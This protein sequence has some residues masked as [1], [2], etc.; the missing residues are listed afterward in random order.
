[1]KNIILLLTF[2]L[3][4]F[5][6]AQVKPA[7]HIDSLFIRALKADTD[8]IDSQ[9]LAHD[10]KWQGFKPN[11]VLDTGNSFTGIMSLSETGTFNLYPVY[12]WYNSNKLVFTTST[13]DQ[14]T[15]KTIIHIHRS[16]FHWLNDTTAI[17]MP[18][19]KP[20]HKIKSSSLLNHSQIP[21]GHSAIMI[22]RFTQFLAA[23]MSAIEQ[24]WPA[25]KIVL[26]FN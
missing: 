6:N 8:K 22:S 7:Q 23:R 17:V 4:A 18:Y 24:G 16:Q 3:P 19:K 13:P 15:G 21:V 2:L 26:A 25:N 9:F 12:Y 14:K 10:P 5:A 20:K 1:M 11:Y